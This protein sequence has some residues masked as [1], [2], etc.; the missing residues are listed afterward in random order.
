MVYGI[1]NSS[2]W[3]SEELA[4]IP[5]KLGFPRARMIKGRHE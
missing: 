1:R 5:R 2:G 3:E 4:C